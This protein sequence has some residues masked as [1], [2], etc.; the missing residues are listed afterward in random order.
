MHKT[1][2]FPSAALKP[3]GLKS[4]A[5]L[6]GL[7]F[8]SKRDFVDVLICERRDSSRWSN[9]YKLGIC[10]PESH[11]MIMMNETKHRSVT[12]IL[13]AATCFLMRASAHVG[14]CC[15]W[16]C[17]I[18]GSQVQKCTLCAGEQA[19]I[20]GWGEQSVNACVNVCHDLCFCTLASRRCVV[21]IIIHF[22]SSV[23]AR[24]GTHL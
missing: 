15:V 23:C 13:Y 19:A 9:C 6:S 14:G 1:P 5:Q 20:Q 7:N 21:D 8:N 22:K 3:S 11:L 2:S 16:S 4:A 10:L 17:P 12:H 18:R 24:L